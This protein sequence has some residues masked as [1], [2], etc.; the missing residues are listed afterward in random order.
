MSPSPAGRRPARPA[1]SPGRRPTSQSPA[2]TPS[3]RL[4]IALIA[5]VALALGLVA[6]IVL[7]MG[8]GEGETLEVGTPVITGEAL[9]RFAS[10]ATDTAVGLVIPE[11]SGADFAGN[12]VSITRDG[13][14]KVL[15]FFSH[16]CGVC[17]QEVPLIMSWL[18][19]A[20]LPDNLDLISVSTGVRRNQVNY[21][22]SKW[23]ASEG[24]T[25][26]VIMDD[27]ADSVGSAFGLSA[28]PYFVFVDAEDRVAFRITGGLPIETIEGII[29]QMLDA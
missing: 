16:W 25:V 13:R 24:W 7:T 20:T 4:P 19:G 3:R 6:V 8:A 28:Y 2:A 15:M 17:R 9:P 1:A 22:P 29:A 5:G 21:P 12:P 26:P 14:P 11:V 18:P 27:A 10:V 23:L